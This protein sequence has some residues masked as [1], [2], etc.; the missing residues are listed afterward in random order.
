VLTHHFVPAPL[1]PDRPER[2]TRLGVVG[3]GNARFELA[4]QLLG[5][6][7]RTAPPGS[8]P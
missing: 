8:K 3:H 1:G 5:P 2:F 7:S 6:M 4:R